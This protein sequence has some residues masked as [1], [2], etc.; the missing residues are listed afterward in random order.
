MPLTLDQQEHEMP[1]SFRGDVACN[2]SL[3]SKKRIDR[4]TSARAAQEFHA[5][6]DR[7]DHS[8]FAESN[9]TNFVK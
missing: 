8:V 1:D 4:I 5:Q 9:F 2:V 6:N 7:T 3:P